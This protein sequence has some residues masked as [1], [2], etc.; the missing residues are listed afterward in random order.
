VKSDCWSSGS[1]RA[2][3]WPSGT[4][5]AR[6]PSRAN[7]F[8]ASRRRAI[9]GEFIGGILL[10][11][12]LLTRP[13]ALWIILV[14]GGAAFHVHLG[15]PLFST[16]GAAKEMALLYFAPALCFLLTGSGRTGIDRAIRK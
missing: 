8:Q 9:L 10:A 13:A 1:G 5:W 7:L 11:L 3:R 15:D 2:W 4:G 12:G 14:M 6:S 16:G